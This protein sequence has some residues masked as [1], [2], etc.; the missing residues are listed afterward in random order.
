MREMWFVVL[1]GLLVAG[2]QPA[3]AQ[4]P[5][6]APAA[7]ADKVLAVTPE[8]RVLGTPD[9]PI[10]IVEYASLSC[11]HCAHFAKEVLPKLK[12]KWIDTGKAKLVV[13]A[14]PHNEPALLAETV[15]RCIAPERYFPVVE[16]LFEMQDQWV[17]AQDMRVALERITRLAGIGKKDFDACLA[18]K[19]IENQVLQ[20]RLTA[21]TQLGVQSIPTYFINGKRYDGEPTF[22]GFDQ[23]LSGLAAKS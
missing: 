20:S 8:D 16:T 11:P 21:S 1:V 14:F 2:A 5:R 9:A 12:Q 4:A 13:R 15:A 23:L 6:P 18:N 10:T 3:I 19:G 17:V 7:D 22:E